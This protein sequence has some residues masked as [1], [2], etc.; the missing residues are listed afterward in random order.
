MDLW[1]LIS[2]RQEFDPEEV[3]RA[4]ETQVAEP[5]PDPRTCM[6]IHDAA[7]GLLD[8]WGEPRYQE[9]LTRAEL[10]E[11]IQPFITAEYEKVGFPSLAKRI[12]RV[13]RKETI[14]RFLRALG[15]EL[16]EPATLIIGGS[17]SLILNG[18]LSRNTEDV[19]AVDEVPEPLRALGPALQNLE[20]ALGLQLAHFQSHYLPQGWMDRTR[21]L[22]QFG[23]LEVH[24]VDPLDVTA[25]KL[26]SRR[27]KDLGDL[28]ALSNHFS[29]AE[30]R[31]RVESSPSHLG[32]PKLCRNLDRNWFVLYGE[33]FSGGE[34][35]L[36]EDSL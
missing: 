13:T 27:S 1:E 11:R 35:P 2:T 29:A 6:L 33:T 19:H 31:A 7:A 15:G 10:Q 24:L 5:D 32:D 34:L 30:L 8:Y 21:S 28:N 18:L 23:R 4:I 9:W 20:N 36:P 16:R 22:G 14:L 17:S 3:A 25:G 12:Q 26:L